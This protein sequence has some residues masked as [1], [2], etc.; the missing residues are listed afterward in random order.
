MGH[1]L[2][3]IIHGP[4]DWTH[5]DHY[6]NR[7]GD[8]GEGLNEWD[9]ALIEDDEM[10]HSNEYQYTT[11]E[12]YEQY[13]KKFSPSRDEDPPESQIR[14][15]RTYHKK[16]KSSTACD[17]EI[18]RKKEKK[19]KSEFNHSEENILYDDESYRKKEKKLK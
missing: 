11:D 6:E 19:S 13:Q 7:D 5:D 18:Y 17:D 8:E 12:M 1:D 4:G 2:R 16:S 10:I 9:E 3:D 14:I 15:E